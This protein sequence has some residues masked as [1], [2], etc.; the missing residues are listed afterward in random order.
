[1][2]AKCP[3]SDDVLALRH[4]DQDQTKDVPPPLHLMK[5]KIHNSSKAGCTFPMCSIW[6][7]GFHICKSLIYCNNVHSHFAPA[8]FY[9]CLEWT[10]QPPR[11]K[12]KKEVDEVSRFGCV[13]HRSLQAI[14]GE[15]GSV[16]NDAIWN[17]TTR[18]RSF[19]IKI[20]KYYTLNLEMSWWAHTTNLVVFKKQ[21]VDDSVE[22]AH[23]GRVH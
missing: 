15:G 13:G 7:G 14:S 10:I 8:H 11:S 22:L 4:H 16:K 12:N 19:V 18:C 23:G 2:C 5:R 17:V 9:G 1:M 21:H 3:E 20:S 6:L